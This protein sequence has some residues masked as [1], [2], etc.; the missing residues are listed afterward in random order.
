MK[1]VALVRNELPGAENRTTPKKGI[2]TRQDKT[3]IQPRRLKVDIGT[4]KTILK[5][6]YSRRTNTIA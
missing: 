2:N 4:L 6:S 1:C 5:H 3:R